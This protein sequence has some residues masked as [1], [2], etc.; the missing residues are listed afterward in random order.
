MPE[1][2]NCTITPFYKNETIYAYFIQ[3]NEGYLLH[4][5]ALD[6]VETHP[7]TDEELSRL[8][9][10]TGGTCSCGYNYDWETNP[11]EF[12]A[13]PETEVPADNA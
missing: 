10:F 11:R 1:I 12:Y 13:V 7:V 4:D 5:R 6:I 9:G 8:A 2:L 3:A